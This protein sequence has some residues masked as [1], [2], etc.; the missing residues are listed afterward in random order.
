MR[1]YQTNTLHFLKTAALAFVVSVGENRAAEL[2]SLPGVSLAKVELGMNESD[3]IELYPSARKAGGSPSI[4]Q[5]WV[6]QG[7]L[8]LLDFRQGMLALITVSRGGLNE[9]EQ[10]QQT[11][12]LAQQYVK[13]F[14]APEVSITAK[15]LRKGVA[16]ISALVY[17][18]NAY[19]PSTKA[20][21]ESSELELAITIYDQNLRGTER[22]FFS[23]S[24]LLNELNRNTPQPKEMLKRDTYFDFVAEYVIQ[25]A[26][27]TSLENA[28]N[29]AAPN[30]IG[31]VDDGVNVQTKVQT[32]H[33]SKPTSTSSEEPTSS[34]PW[35]IIVVLIVAA[36]VLLWLLVKKR[37]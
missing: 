2:S 26:N 37:K 32:S 24:Q 8:H 17:D 33:E 9:A 19:R 4:Q 34:T 27:T 15:L 5:Y 14:G 11:S 20:I 31:Q 21:V 29:Q 35:S 3:F 25:H 12:D 22:L 13:S 28:A 23:A 30:N 1:T 16:E 7:A 10:R 6:M 18:L 36:T